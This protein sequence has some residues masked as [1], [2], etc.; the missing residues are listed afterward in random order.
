MIRGG[1]GSCFGWPEPRLASAQNTTSHAEH[2]TILGGLCKA[3]YG[4]KNLRL[5][6]AHGTIGPC[7]FW[8][9]SREVR[10]QLARGLCKAW[11]GCKNLRPGM[12]RGM[13]GLSRFRL[14]IKE[15]RAQLARGLDTTWHG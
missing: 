15:V 13:I 5:G 1:Y 11:Y 9:A 14:T 8:P 7:R 4:G 6:T 12:A 3:W 2:N 10:A